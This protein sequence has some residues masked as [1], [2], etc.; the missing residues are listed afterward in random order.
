MCENVIRRMSRRD[1]DGFAMITA[2]VVAAVA[3]VLTATLL[4]SGEHLDRG[5]FRDRKWQTA[6]QVAESGVQRTLAVELQ[7]ARLRR[8]QRRERP[9]R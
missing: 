7:A 8:Q 6:L 4:A 2:V 3:L 9:G 5:T 1:E